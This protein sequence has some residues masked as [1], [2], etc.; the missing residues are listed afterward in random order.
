MAASIKGV[1]GSIVGIIAASLFIPGVLLAQQSSTTTSGTDSNQSGANATPSGLEEIVVTAQRRKES[2]QNVPIAIT[3]LSAEQLSQSGTSDTY[4]LAAMVPGMNVT[5]T[6]SIA[7]IVL[8]GVGT[9]NLT[10]G[11]EG[12][13]AMYIDG[14]YQAAPIGSILDLNNVQSVDVLKGPQGTLFGRNATGGVIQITTKTPQETPM[15]DVSVSYGNYDTVKTDLYATG[16]AAPGLATDLAFHYKDQGD[17]WGK[18]LYD[19]QDVYHG[20]DISLRNKWLFDP[21]DHNK[22]TLSLDYST[23]WSDINAQVR[24]IPPGTLVGLP[25]FPGY[26]NVDINSPGGATTTT[27][28]VSVT[29]EYDFEVAS[30]KSITAYRGNKSHIVLDQDGTSSTAPS[31][32]VNLTLIDDDFDRTISQEFQVLSAPAERLHWVG[33]LYFFRGSAGYDGDGF[34]VLVNSPISTVLSTLT[35]TSYAAFGQAT[36]E[37]L[38]NT[39]LTVGLRYTEDDQAVDAASYALPGYELAPGYPAHGYKRFEKLTDRFAL[40]Y[41]FTSSTMAYASYSTGFKSGLFNTISPFA[42]GTLTPEAINPEVLE[43]YELGVKTDLFDRTLRFD[44]DGFHYDFSN[45]QV[46]QIVQGATVVRN[47]A[48]AEIKGVDVDATWE[49]IR[50]LDFTASFEYLDARYTNFPGAPFYGPNPAGGEYAPISGNA[51]GNYMNFSPKYSGRLAAEYTVPSAVGD[52][53]ML[54]DYYYNNGFAWSV[55]NR[56]WQPSYSLVGASLRWRSPDEREQIRLW[57]KNLADKQYL[58][59]AVEVSP[60]GNHG[61]PAE[62]RT[63]GVTFSYHFGALTK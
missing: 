58:G 38:P 48:S 55:D 51:A 10:L 57:G 12:A 11:D 54:A 36:L 35:T 19:G 17:G 52:F 39:N 50:R 31:P 14:V 34:S 60:Y 63:Y 4:D 59:Y 44:V 22:I 18:N 37:V 8:R 16:G 61:A 3:A 30:L 28:G 41:H 27:W 53:T 23:N 32:A 5:S 24:Q 21:G 56:L 33:G 1:I 6:S 25:A 46:G 43:A 62:P 45:L 49:P 26:Y 7:V 15:A 29:D 47:A 13:V 20:H 2:I 9:S 40:D 42:P